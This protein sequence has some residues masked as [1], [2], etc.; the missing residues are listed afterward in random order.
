MIKRWEFRIDSTIQDSIYVLMRTAIATASIPKE[1]PECEI[2]GNDGT[3]YHFIAN[4]YQAEC[5]S[6]SGGNNAE[7]VRIMDAVCQAVKSQNPVL[8]QPLLP[9][10]NR[11]T[12][13][14]DE[15]ACR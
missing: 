13:A 6:P 11:L 5:W 4:Y 9:V 10:I 14:Y 8:L 7:L 2:V 15:H 3:I 12:S 1:D